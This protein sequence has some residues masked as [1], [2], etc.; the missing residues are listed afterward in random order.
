[1]T[2]CMLVVQRDFIIQCCLCADKCMSNVK[3]SRDAAKWIVMAQ[4]CCKE[5]TAVRVRPD[6]E[7]VK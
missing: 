1:M 6:L 7:R 3:N 4:G 5:P 2:T